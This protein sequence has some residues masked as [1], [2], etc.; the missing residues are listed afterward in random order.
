MAAFQKSD[1]KHWPNFIVIGPGK[2][3]TS[4]LFQVF[5]AHP[6]I[7][8]SSAKET[9]FFDSEYHRGLNW[10]A[11]FFRR[12]DADQQPHAVGEVS[13][14]YIFSEEAPGRIREHFPEMKLL[15]TLRNPVERAFSHYLFERRNANVSGTFEEALQQRPDFLSRGCYNKHLT[16]Y[17]DVFPAE[18][19]K[20]LIYDDLKA[21]NASFAGELF[22]FINVG[23]LPNP[24]ILGKRVLGASEA[25]NRL[26]AKFSVGAAH[27]IRAAGF[28]EVVTKIKNSVVSKMLFKPIDRENY[29]TMRPETKLRLCDYFRDDVTALS[30]RLE[31]DLVAQWLDPIYN[32]LKLENVA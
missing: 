29:P 10:Y 9:I 16:R 5:A 30:E 6:E 2:A 11:K 17:Y 22:D 28:P 19:I 31:R 8:T 3:G 23:P 20:V 14:T 4:W 12:C 18:Q 21:D 24:E 15:S 7:C 32:E 1:F 26:A 25:R 27:M 13:N